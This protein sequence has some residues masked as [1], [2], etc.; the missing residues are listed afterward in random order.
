MDST[1]TT[2]PAWLEEGV[3]VNTNEV[4]AE[5]ASSQSLEVRAYVPAAKRDLL[6]GKSAKFYSTSGADAIDLQLVTLANT[7]IDVLDDQSLAVAN[8]GEMAVVA[9]SAGELQ[10]LQGW[11]MA[12]L[13]PSDEPLEI[14][15]EKTG[16]VMFPAIAKSL[17][18]S[19]FDRLY[20]VVI[21]ESGF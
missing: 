8:G 4:L 15:S 6:E 13:A 17:A 16:Y 2:V 3:W 12:I 1:V 20:G 18:A 14:N 5:L 7:N 11:M 9:S 21:R 10:P 19:V